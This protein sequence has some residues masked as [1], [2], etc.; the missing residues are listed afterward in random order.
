MFADDVNLH[1]VFE[2]NKNIG[3]WEGNLG[4]VFALRNRHFL[5]DTFSEDSPDELDRRYGHETCNA[6]QTRARAEALD[7]RI[8]ENQVSQVA[9][10]TRRLNSRA[11]AAQPEPPSEW[12]EMQRREEK[13]RDSVLKCSAL[14]LGKE[15]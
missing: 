9:L 1:G 3:F 15:S 6:D 7:A 8:D 12:D 4:P 2:G 5:P 13:R 14:S 10:V 11:V